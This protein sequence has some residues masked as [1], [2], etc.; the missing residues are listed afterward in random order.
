M[1]KLF[2][3]STLYTKTFLVSFGAGILVSLVLVILGIFDLLSLFIPLGIFLGSAFSAFSY[4][5]LGKIETMNIDNNAK[6]KFTTAVMFVRLALLLVFI[7]IEVFVQ[8][9]TEIVLFNPY[10]FLGAYFFTS[11]VFGLFYFGEKNGK[12]N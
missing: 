8:L 9:K 3:N 7:A 5:A 1:K 11:I 6:A 2:E 4:F 12:R 10:G